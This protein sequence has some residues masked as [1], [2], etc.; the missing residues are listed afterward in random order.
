MTEK[1]HT[2]T[3]IYPES[4][5][6]DY[7][8]QTMQPPIQI[9]TARTCIATRTSAGP[10][11]CITTTATMAVSDV[12]RM[13]VSYCKTSRF[14]RAL[15]LEQV[16]DAVWTDIIETMDLEEARV[17]FVYYC[18]WGNLER[19]REL[20]GQ[21][22]R[23]K[24]LHAWAK[25][26]CFNQRAV[27]YACEKGHLEVMKH[28]QQTYRNR[29]DITANH[30]YAIKECCE[31]GHSDLLQFLLEVRGA[32][33]R[34]VIETNPKFT[35]RIR[36]FKPTCILL[37]VRAYQDLFISHSIFEQSELFHSAACN[38]WLDVAELLIDG[39]YN[40]LATISHI[41]ERTFGL[42]CARDWT[43]L[44][45]Q[46]L[47]KITDTKLREKLVCIGL[48][49][50][51]KSPP[52]EVGLM[53]INDYSADITEKAIIALCSICCNQDN[54]RHKPHRH[55]IVNKLLDCCG[56]VLESSSWHSILQS[57]CETGCENLLHRF[58]TDL[59]SKIE[60][61]AY[62]RA[63]TRTIRDSYWDSQIGAPISYVLAFIELFKEKIYPPV[64]QFIFKTACRGAIEWCISSRH[65]R[66]NLKYVADCRYVGMIVGMLDCVGDR[67]DKEPVINELRLTCIKYGSLSI[68]QT[69]L[70]FYGHTVPQYLTTEIINDIW[71][72]WDIVKALVEC[73]PSIVNVQ[74]LIQFA[75]DIILKTPQGYSDTVPAPIDRTKYILDRYFTEINTDHI[76][77]LFS[78]S[79]NK[80]YQVLAIED[81]KIL[82]DDHKHEKGF[83][84]IIGKLDRTHANT[85]YVLTDY[86][87]RGIKAHRS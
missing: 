39:Y 43:H 64:L 33:I 7:G 65:S 36:Y 51:A 61:L 86:R 50:A 38:G 49:Q 1:A 22:K 2:R 21:A 87:L 63:L 37:L 13:F 77:D 60:P 15:E 20:E 9:L 58:A 70:K 5:C 79:S 53:F 52:L 71:K 69:L 44:L 82:I 48:R 66:L 76:R 78:L 8:L 81:V 23:A 73:K 74:A 35:E 6:I 18:R 75:I 62:G 14:N 12:R 84:S 85:A 54:R 16:L 28:L 42:M 56:S 32:E 26:N 72:E 19:V 25:S 41:H 3:S 24:V 30:N 57:T 29:I 10:S 46:V 4:F 59:S 11:V 31:Q 83:D 47:D 68:I 80:L 67:I 27:L 40:T 55:E 17:L 34:T 45:K